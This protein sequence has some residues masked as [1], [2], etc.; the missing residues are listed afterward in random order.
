MRVCQRRLYVNR[1]PPIARRYGVDTYG[2]VLV[3]TRERHRRLGEAR[4]DLII[5][6]LLDLGRTKPKVIGFAGRKSSW[7]RFQS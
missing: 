2:A 3:A 5:G 7:P 6:P 1:N 4:E